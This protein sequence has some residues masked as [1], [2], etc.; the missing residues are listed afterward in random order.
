MSPVPWKQE[1]NFASAL[2]LHSCITV[3]LKE[4]SNGTAVLYHIFILAKDKA[5]I[6][7]SV[8]LDGYTSVFSRD[9]DGELAEL[10]FTN[11]GFILLIASLASAI[12]M[13]LTLPTGVLNALIAATFGLAFLASAAVAC[14]KKSFVMPIMALRRAGRFIWSDTPFVNFFSLIYIAV[15]LKGSS[16]LALRDYVIF[17][18]IAILELVFM[19]ARLAAA[20]AET[21][22]VMLKRLVDSEYAVI[23]SKCLPAARSPP[24]QLE[25][26]RI[27]PFMSS[28]RLFVMLY[29]TAI[30]HI[31]GSVC[32]ASGPATMAIPKNPGFFKDEAAQYGWRVYRVSP[33]YV[34]IEDCGMA[35]RYTKFI[36]WSHGVLLRRLGRRRVVWLMHT[37][38]DERGADCWKGNINLVTGLKETWLK[39]RARFRPMTSG[40]EGDARVNVVW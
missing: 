13:N 17:R 31:E 5:A 24:K 12:A 4:V 20:D 30:G 7:T 14:K 2:L 26:S 28:Q 19:K 23:S 3:F 27:V 37:G 9:Q 11:T 33:T 8:M 34:F 38:Q 29:K 36:S 39:D 1:I 18:S 40:D 22:Q 16:E 10:Y 25:H 15:V 32:G 21:Q 35:A 6:D